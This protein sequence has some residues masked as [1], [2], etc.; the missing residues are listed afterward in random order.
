MEPE[1]IAVHA[2]E[3]VEVEGTAIEAAATPDEAGS[4][5]ITISTEPYTV[6]L[7]TGANGFVR[8][9]AEEGAEAVLFVGEAGVVQALTFC[10]YEVELP[11]PAP[12][13]MCS[14]DIPE[15]YHVHLWSGIW[16]LELGPAS[17][18]ALWL[19]LMPHAGAHEHE[20]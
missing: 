2:C 20:H 3:H 18:D 12:N 11:E 10:D 14:E 5:S 19:L 13:G 8:I 15:H 9:V 4:A 17:G 7:P 16:H 6:G 1:P